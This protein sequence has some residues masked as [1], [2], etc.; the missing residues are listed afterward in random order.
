MKQKQK[1]DCN[2]FPAFIGRFNA[3]NV[4]LL[5]QLIDPI[6]YFILKAKKRATLMETKQR[7]IIDGFL[8]IKLIIYDYNG[9]I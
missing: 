7:V 1:N 6:I 2:V 3:F 9:R 8:H 4:K 5:P